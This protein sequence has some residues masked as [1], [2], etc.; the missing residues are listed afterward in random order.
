MLYR[1]IAVFYVLGKDEAFFPLSGQRV[2][3]RS[4]LTIRRSSMRVL[5]PAAISFLS[6]GVSG[7]GYSVARNLKIGT[8]TLISYS[9]GN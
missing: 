5:T 6:C 7:Q 2:C 8:N 4:S 1:A 3:T 9:T